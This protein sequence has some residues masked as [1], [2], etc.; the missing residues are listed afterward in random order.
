MSRVTC[1][2]ILQNESIENESVESSRVESS[3]AE[4]IENESI[5]NESIENESESVDMEES[6]CNESKT[7]RSRQTEPTHLVTSG[8]STAVENDITRRGVITEEGTDCTEDGVKERV[9]NALGKGSREVMGRENGLMKGKV[10]DLYIFTDKEEVKTVVPAI[11]TGKRKYIKKDT[12]FWEAKR[13][14]G[15]GNK[16]IVTRSGDVKRSPGASN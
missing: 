2:V 1:H 6:N 16:K 10:E 9:D 8:L 5:E 3:R 13:L 15:K 4:S 11:L 7:K 14:K 12:E